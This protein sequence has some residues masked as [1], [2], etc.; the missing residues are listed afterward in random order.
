MRR[1]RSVP[2]DQRTVR[3][4]YG[5]DIQRQNAVGMTHRL[6]VGVRSRLERIDTVA[7]HYTQRR[8]RVGTVRSDDVR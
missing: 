8:V 6:T 4:A 5:R 2:D 7:L 1:D 3:G